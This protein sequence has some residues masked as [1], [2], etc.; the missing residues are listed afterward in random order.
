MPTLLQVVG[1]R[2]VLTAI[3]RY[4]SKLIEWEETAPM[5]VP[6][7]RKYHT[8]FISDP[9]SPICYD[10]HNKDVKRIRDLAGITGKRAVT[11]FHRSDKA[12]DALENSVNTRDI[13]SAVGWHLT[14]EGQKTYLKGALVTGFGRQP[15]GH[16]GRLM[17][18]WIA[19]SIAWL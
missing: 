14:S 10:T 2:T 11:H 17:R 7:W 12:S 16:E 8:V 5:P 4:L 1:G 19:R 13:E 3:D 6:E 15:P 18:A 9:L